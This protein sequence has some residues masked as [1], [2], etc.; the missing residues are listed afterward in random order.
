MLLLVF[1]PNS[2][3]IFMGMKGFPVPQR[4]IPE[5]E[6]RKLEKEEE[7]IHFWLFFIS[8]MLGKDSEKYWN[9][10]KYTVIPSLE[11]QKA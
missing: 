7:I 11:L 9:F 10:S 1:I 2:T 6:V 4:G 3:M 8:V 5:E